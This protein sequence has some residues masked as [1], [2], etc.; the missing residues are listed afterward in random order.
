MR[1]YDSISLVACGSE[2]K[3]REIHQ[4]VSFAFEWQRV[5]PLLPAVKLHWL[6]PNVKTFSLHH[7]FA[8]RVIAEANDHRF[9]LSCPGAGVA[10]RHELC[11]FIYGDCGGRRLPML[12]G[13]S[14]LQFETRSH[15]F[16]KTIGRLLVRRRHCTDAE[17]TS[18]AEFWS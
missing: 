6:I 9:R 3:G 5:V 18:A 7:H 16:W 12:R 13:D 2:S 8:S 1:K 15:Q 10:V 17:R 14:F 4:A 11:V